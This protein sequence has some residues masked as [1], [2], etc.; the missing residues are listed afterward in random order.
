MLQREPGLFILILVIKA[1][2]S[3]LQSLVKRQFQMLYYQA[4]IVSSYLML[5][6]E[7]TMTAMFNNEL[8]HFNHWS[9][10]NLGPGF[11]KKYAEESLQ[12]SRSPHENAQTWHGMWLVRENTAGLTP[13]LNRGLRYDW[14][15][16]SYH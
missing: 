5:Y 9:S 7:Q 12:V 10:T 14:P 8:P 11:R 13:F 3:C 15:S 2:I 1:I 16:E 6:H 4:Y